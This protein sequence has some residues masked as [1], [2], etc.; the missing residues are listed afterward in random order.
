MRLGEVFR[1]VGLVAVALGLGAILATMVVGCADSAERGAGPGA[2]E[3][4]QATG[5]LQ[6]PSLDLDAP[7]DFQTASFAFG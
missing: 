1:S 7:L 5:Q 3:G 4:R 2:S 6:L